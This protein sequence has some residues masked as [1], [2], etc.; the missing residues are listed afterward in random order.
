VQIA[1]YLGAKKVIASGRNVEALK[2]VAA[3]GADVTIPLA[4]DEAATEARFRDVFAGGVDVVIDYLWGPSAERILVAA[5][6]A[7]PDA[8]PI[9]FVQVGSLG[10]QEITLPG[11]VLRAKAI[12]LMGS[13]LGSAPVG[14]L[15]G[16]IR[17]ML[18]AV[19]PAGFRV[20]T[21][22]VPLSEVEAAWPADD[23]RQRT[24]FTI[25]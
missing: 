18:E 12:E 3:L 13:G 15:L 7:A 14:R 17:E 9:R 10:G 4:G 24:V 20:A 21:K 1:R 11:A 8:V 22:P 6:K 23:S 2:E 19:V 16:E 25:A 5:A